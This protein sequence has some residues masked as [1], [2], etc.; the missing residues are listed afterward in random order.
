MLRS[1]CRAAL[2]TL[3]PS[4]PIRGFLPRSSFSRAAGVSTQALTSQARFARNDRR[5]R[6]VRGKD[7]SDAATQRPLD[8]FPL[9]EGTKEALE[10]RGVKEL[11]PIQSACFV[12]V[13]DGLD[14][15]GRARTGTGKTLAFALPLVERILQLPR[16]EPNRPH[17]LVM[18]PTRELARQVCE[19]IHSVSSGGVT[20]ESFY[21]GTAYDRQFSAL[22]RGVDVVVG[23]PGRLMDHIN[24]KQSMH[25]S[26]VKTLVLDEAD[27]M[28]DMGFQQDVEDVINN[29]RRHNGGRHEHQTLLFSATIPRWVHDLVERHLKKDKVIVD[30]VGDQDNQTPSNLEHIAM[31]CNFHNRGP[32]IAQIIREMTDISED[33]RA[34]K[35]KVLVFA[36]RKAEC[37]ALGYCSS[38]RS[39]GGS[40]GV[41]HG[42]IHQ[43]RRER[44]L[45]M[46]RKGECPVV[47]ATDV[48]ARG[49]DVDGVDLVIMTEVPN[50]PEKYIHRSGRTARAGKKGTCITL[51][52]PGDE[53]MLQQIE[54]N[55]N[56]PMDMKQLSEEAQEA[57]RTAPPSPV[58]SG[59]G[60]GGGGY[61]GGGRG[62]YGG[63]GYRGGGGGGGYRGGGGYGDRS[64]DRW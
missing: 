12:H 30:L 23:T 11:Y 27:R 15:I 39:L 26:D 21:G 46:F 31:K 62:G 48:A 63:G 55:I 24:T 47:I 6:E 58:Q 25:L 52:G 50:N 38:M 59:Y 9:S 3:R 33:N 37:N 8:D 4:A 34:P 49:I 1:L 57:G 64:T 22:E 29:I 7:G 13:N 45:D 40:P 53:R 14:V 43:G 41:L 42:D 35:S 28:L 17:A 51:V 44:T 20:A 32:V 16:A 36:E 5:E 10:R 61:G 54:Q 19:D 18:L 2:P 60:G 56:K